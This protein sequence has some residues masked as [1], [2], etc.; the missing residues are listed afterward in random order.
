MMVAWCELC[1][2]S[3]VFEEGLCEPC[4]EGKRDNYMTSRIF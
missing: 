1:D 3:P 4:L 2:E